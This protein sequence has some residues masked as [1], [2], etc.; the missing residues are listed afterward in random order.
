MI[1]SR[2]NYPQMT[3]SFRLVN[4]DILPNHPNDSS[5]RLYPSSVSGERWSSAHPWRRFAP[6]RSTRTPTG[7]PWKLWLGGF[8]WKCWVNIPNE[9]AI[10]HRDNDQHNHWVQWGLAYFQ[11]HP[12]IGE[13]QPTGDDCWESP[14]TSC[15]WETSMVGLSAG[16]WNMDLS[17]NDWFAE[18]YCNI[19]IMRIV[20]NH[21]HLFEFPYVWTILKVHIF[22]PYRDIWIYLRSPSSCT[23][24]TWHH[25]QCHVFLLK[26]RPWFS[27]S[28]HRKLY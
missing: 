19:D 4:Y 3:S 5:T 27:G 25:S 17:E 24:H 23:W 22:K 2:A 26:P 12:G 8:V 1:V 7:G 14:M 15:C 11:T 28:P 18:T 6:W 21:Q 16:L 9:I 10:F 13:Q 20:I